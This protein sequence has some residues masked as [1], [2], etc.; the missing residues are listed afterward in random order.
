M[1]KY[2]YNSILKLMIL[3][4]VVVVEFEQTGGLHGVQGGLSRY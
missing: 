1:L 3:S 4:C 2:L